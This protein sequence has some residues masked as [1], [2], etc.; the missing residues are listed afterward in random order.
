MPPAPL[1]ID[2]QQR[3]EAL[4]RYAVLDTPSEQ[5]FDRVARLAAN[6]IGAPIALVSLVD[7]CRQ[8]FK[9]RVGLSVEETPRDLAFCAHAILG[10]EVFV[11]P[12][13]ASDPRFQDNPLVTGDLGIRFYAGAP[14]RTHDG[15]K[16]GT[17]CVIDHS[18]REMDKASLQVLTDLSALVVDELEL[19][20]AGQ[21]ALKE[22]ELR[23]KAEA[24][25]KRLAEENRIARMVA[26]EALA[27]KSLFL[28][29]MTH[30]LRTP[31]NAVIGYAELMKM[32]IDSSPRQTLADY[33]ENIRTSG[34][35]LLDLIN[36]VLDVSRLEA[37]RIEISPEPLDLR[38]E[39][40][41]ALR[42]VKGLAFERGVKLSLA[43]GPWP[44]VLADAR[45]VRH[46]L[47]NLLSNA[48]KFSLPGKQ[49]IVDAAAARDKV[50]I[51]VTD[52]GSGISAADLARIGRPYEQAG[53]ES[54][55]RK[56]TGLGLA[57][58]HTL[59]QEHG[60][61]IHIDSVEGQGTTVSFDLPAAAVVTPATAPA[62]TA[63]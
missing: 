34:T 13:A 7:E 20:I 44:A 21:R 16:L 59:V 24:D 63:E 43:S 36:D 42:L 38:V 33:A 32:V 62:L 49:V 30:E 1:P 25:L 9:A 50:Q 55:R 47:L 18:P 41:R 17:L 52:Q 35:Y 22:I 37:G 23:R 15:F 10:D 14:L 56:G 31:L 60:G 12:D 46:I 27:A 6:I 51:T 4:E 48:I 39:A 8:W 26:E 57:L 29:T 28:A 19:R 45:A 53:S 3:L 5:Q 54:D 40:E 11:V 61:Q 58:C 2:E